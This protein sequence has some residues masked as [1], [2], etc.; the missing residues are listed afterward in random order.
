MITLSFCVLYGV[1]SLR[2]TSPSPHTLTAQYTSHKHT[3]S[4][5]IGYVS[6]KRKQT[7]IIDQ[8]QLSTTQPAARDYYVHARKHDYY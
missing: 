6:T 1:G 5:I 8:R 3:C 7:I 4:M 2:S